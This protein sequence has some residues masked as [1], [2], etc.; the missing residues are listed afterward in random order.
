MTSALALMPSRRALRRLDALAVA[1]ALVFAV[2]GVVAGVNLHDLGRLGA[3][4]A[5][6]A[7]SLDLAARGL[8]ALGEVP[9]VGDSADRF[10]VTIGQAAE[11]IRANAADVRG[12]TAVLAWVV[13]LAI[14][15]LPLPL[16]AGVYLP[17]RLARAREVRRLRRLLAGPVDPRLV[18]H[19]ARRAANGLPY[20]QL[21]RA[22]ESPWVDLAAGRHIRLA[23]AELDRLGVPVPAGWR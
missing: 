1:W 23:A 12:S 7:E 3:G 16:L 17:L 2:L 10:A 21:R 5:D 9:I 14:G 8:A 11:S 19:L 18:E 6:V 13:G 15:M 20:G 4:L 22:S